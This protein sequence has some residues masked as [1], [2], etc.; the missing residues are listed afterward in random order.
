MLNFQ[1]NDFYWAQYWILAGFISHILGKRQD[2]YMKEN[3]TF[4]K[5]ILF[6]DS[7]EN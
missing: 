7:N 2:I 3:R 1:A 6:Y 5:C 4:K